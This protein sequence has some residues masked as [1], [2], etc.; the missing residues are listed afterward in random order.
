MTRNAEGSG[1]TIAEPSQTIGA[2]FVDMAAGTAFNA[3][4]RQRGAR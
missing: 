2:G 3:P 4:S 1:T